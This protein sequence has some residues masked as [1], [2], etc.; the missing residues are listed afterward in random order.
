MVRPSSP[1]PAAVGPLLVAVGVVVVTALDGPSPADQIRALVPLAAVL[2]GMGLLLRDLAAERR[3]AWL[4]AS[5]RHRRPVDARTAVGALVI[6]GALVRLLSNGASL[7]AETSAVIAAL[8]LFCGG[9]LIALPYLLRVLRDLDA[10]RAERVRAQQFAEVAAHMHDSVLHTLTLIQ[11]ADPGE[12]AGLARAQER[13]LRAWLYDRRGRALDA[14]AP[15]TFAA[16]LRSAA[17]E[18]EDRHGARIDVVAVGDTELGDGLA[19][20]VAAAREALVNAAKYA[21]GAPI[22]VFAEVEAEAAGGRRI[23]VFVRDRGPGFDLGAVGA[24]RMGIRESIVGRMARHG[25]HGEV[26]TALGAGTE[27][28]LEMRSEARAEAR[29]EMRPETRPESRSELRSEMEDD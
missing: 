15:E 18:V 5:D 29:P 4:D 20:C 19:A 24:D 22:S 14:E 6:G 23:E 12:V 28:R 13:E 21:G 16:A 7:T 1:R 2:L 3:G 11:R 8:I 27:V 10:E 26:R 25:G 17:A 9:V